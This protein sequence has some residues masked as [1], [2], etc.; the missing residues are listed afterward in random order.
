MTET[1]WLACEDARELLR[2]VRTELAAPMAPAGVRKLRLFGCATCRLLW[3]DLPDARSRAAIEFAERLADGAANLKK[4]AKVQKDASKARDQFSSAPW[5][6]EWSAACD[7]AALVERYPDPGAD[8]HSALSMILPETNQPYYDQWK[9]KLRRFADM[10]RDVF[11][12]PF[13]PVN[14]SPSWR[15]DTAVMLARQM[16]EAREFSAMPILADALQDA[17]CDN[18]DVLA[19]CR[20]PG[21][22][23]RG[24]WVCDLVLGKA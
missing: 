16:Y 9:A 15:T 10:L 22:H 2:Y 24:C 6:P 13:R 3:D 12:N 4:L 23:V 1:E 8:A 21:E 20:E 18:E 5:R 17:G 14:F 11:D 19:H 7:A